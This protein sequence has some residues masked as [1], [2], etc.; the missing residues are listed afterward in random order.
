M[1]DSAPVNDV[2]VLGRAIRE[3]FKDVMRSDQEFFLQIKNQEWGG[4]YVDLVGT[5]QVA[6][7]SVCRAVLK[8]I[9]SVH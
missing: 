4:M 7:K 8:P 1:L 2:A 9:V 3:A 5:E 6:N